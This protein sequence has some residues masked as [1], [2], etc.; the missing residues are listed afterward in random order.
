MDIRIAGLH[1]SFAMDGQNIEVLR[2]VDLQIRQGEIMSLTGPS[3]AGKSTFLHI[4]GTLDEPSRGAIYF[5][6]VEIFA[7]EPADIAA[8]RN[9]QVGFVFQFHHLLSEFSA[10]ENVMMPALAQRWPR[11]RANEAAQE[12]LELVGL[13]HRVKHKPGELSGGEQQ[14]VALARALVLQ[15]QLLLAD[16]PTGNLDERTSAE[17]HELLFRINAERNI[18]AVVVTHNTK[19][20]A[21]LPR[22]LVIKAGQIADFEADEAESEAAA[23]PDTSKAVE[24]QP[25]DTQ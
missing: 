16:E 5:D 24:P 9:R 6:E 12:V 4:L 21:M 11:S 18:S 19:L 14:R 23:L 13:P 22:K 3:G 25:G 20:A 15:P 8:F 1:K 7:Q 17:I 2:G 10:L